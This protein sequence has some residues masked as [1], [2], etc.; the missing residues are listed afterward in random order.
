MQA[1]VTN[2]TRVCW[3]P[4]SRASMF[5]QLYLSEPISELTSEDINL[6]IS[7]FTIHNYIQNKFLTRALE[8]GDPIISQNIY[9]KYVVPKAKLKKKKYK[10]LSEDVLR[11]MAS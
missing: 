5:K 6:Y 11:T 4:Q 1:E 7:P 8:V 3:P 2:G 9:L 10:Q